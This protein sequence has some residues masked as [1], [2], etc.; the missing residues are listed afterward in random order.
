MLQSALPELYSQLQLDDKGLWS[1]FAHSGV[2]ENNL[3]VQLARKLTLFQK[4]LVVQ[5]LRPDR[6]H[7]AVV[8]FTLQT[9]GIV[10][11]CSEEIKDS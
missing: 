2:C 5:A 1:G 9:L 3:P 10:K 4:V 8:Q 6:L 11:F 7:S